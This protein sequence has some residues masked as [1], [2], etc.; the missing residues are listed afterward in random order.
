[1]GRRAVTRVEEKVRAGIHGRGVHRR[2]RAEQLLSLRGGRVIGLVVPVVRPHALKRSSRHRSVDLDGH[3][4][5]WLSTGRRA[6]R[7]AHGKRKDQ[8]G[9][10]ALH[11]SYYSSDLTASRSMARPFV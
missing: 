8:E 11:E 4:S 10:A 6:N 2:Q 3:G 9:G 1:Q 5:F 7:K